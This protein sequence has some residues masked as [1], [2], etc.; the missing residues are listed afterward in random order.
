MFFKKAKELAYLKGALSDLKSQQVDTQ[1]QAQTTE[2]APEIPVKQSSIDNSAVIY[3]ILH[4]IFYL[5]GDYV[6]IQFNTARNLI[7]S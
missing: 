2:I 6:Y 1:A 7:K 5:A 3:S 4:S